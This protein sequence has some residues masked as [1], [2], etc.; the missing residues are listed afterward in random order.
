MYSKS[1]DKTT[2]TDYNM[3]YNTQVRLIS[4]DKIAPR[5]NVSSSL[6]KTTKRISSAEQGDLVLISNEDIKP[7]LTQKFLP[8]Y[9]GPYIILE[10]NDNSTVK[11]QI[12]WK[13]PTVHF[14]Q[15]KPYV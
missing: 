6:V 2:D 4:I 8:T 1:T 15:L 3:V 5:C 10:V 13:M 12:G 11:I 9:K 14:N 7:G